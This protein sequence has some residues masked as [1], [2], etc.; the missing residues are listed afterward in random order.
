MDQ[1]NLIVADGLKVLENQVMFDFPNAKLQKCVVHKM[2]NVTKHV[3]L[4]HKQEKQMLFAKNGIVNPLI[5]GDV[6]SQMIFV[7]I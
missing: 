4:K 2:L 5:L 3:S 6:L 7:I 1:V